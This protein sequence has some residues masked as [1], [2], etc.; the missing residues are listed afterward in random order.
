MA[1]DGRAGG[2][3][4]ARAGRMN[5]RRWWWRRGLRA[6]VT[7]TA[8]AG[9]L[10]T[11]AIFDLLLFT[12]LRASLTRSL[13]DSTRQ[14]A[15]SVVALIDARRLPPSVPV[16]PGVTVQVI[17][18]SG[19]ITDASP[20][21]DRLVPMLTR[22]EAL[23]SA[24]AGTGRLLDGPPFDIPARLRVDA[25]RAGDGS[26]VI[27]AV[28][29]GSV[30]D[31]LQVVARALLA[32]TPMLFILFTWLTWLVVGSTLRPVTALRRAA[33]RIT[34][35]GV[36]QSDLPV[37]EARDEVQQ[38][39]LT[40]NDMLSRLAG[41]QA[42]QRALVSDTAH[43]LRSPI[44]SMR[45]QLEV[46]LDHP[47]LQDWESTVR[48][49]HADT[50]RLA[51]LAEDL[52]LL[53]RLDE[54]AAAGGAGRDRR[55]PVD[56]GTLAAD[57]A[58]RYASATAAVTTTAAP[59]VIAPG[60][61]GGLDRLL[62]NLIDNAV[63]YAAG[64]VTVGVRADGR[65]AELT[66]TDDG[67]GIAAGDLERAFDRFARLDCARSRGDDDAGAGLGLAI[68][69]ATAQAHAGTAA[70]RP[71]PGPAGLQAVVRLP[72][73]PAAPGPAVPGA[74]PSAAPPAARPPVP[75]QADALDA[76]PAEDSDAA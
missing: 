16:A 24:A 67:P 57:V 3:P 48:D 12:V 31:S 66:V 21:A 71:A 73:E 43:E 9:L 49:V 41:A 50:L 8:A 68:V 11:F 25:V 52:L 35:T 36:P 63:R 76:G 69:R 26:V 53:A 72:R 38:L 27:A 75:S 34:A 14:A 22:P 33:A 29:Y 62:V 54:R 13:D 15:S 20:D 28:P 40:L 61:P 47:G 37:P 74:G 60:D 51:R 17:G 23:A 45:A 32:G 6:R 7:I 19:R 65:W 58:G 64:Q 55:V 56:L 4:A 39:A 18:P 46:A 2:G 10:V 70:L 59:G 30:A 1:A 44:A 5:V 42:R